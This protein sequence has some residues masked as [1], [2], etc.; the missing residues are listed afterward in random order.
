[1][2]APS[3][4]Y[5]FWHSNQGDQK[6]GTKIAQFLEIEAKTVAKPNKAKISSSNS[7]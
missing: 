4:R 5:P 3:K 6:I 7:I 1:M 2:V